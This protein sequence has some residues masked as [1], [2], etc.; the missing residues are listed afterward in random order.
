MAL[1][2]GRRG[3]RIRGWLGRHRALSWTA[4]VAIAVLVTAG[5]YTLAARPTVGET[6]QDAGISKIKHVVVIMQENRSFDSYFG[7]FPGADGIP[8]KGGVP[9]VCVPDPAKGTC[10]APYYDP[11]DKN[12]GGPHSAANATADIDGGKMDGFIA[13]A[14]NASSKCAPNEPACNGAAG[15]DVMGY[16]DARD[17]PNYWAYARDY[18][19]QDRMFEPNASWSLPAHLYMVSEWSAKCSTAGDPAS[20]VNAL[21]GPALPPDFGAGLRNTIIGQCRAGTATSA[22]QKALAAAGIS[23]DVAAQLHTFILQHCTPT[24]TYAECR[25]AVDKAPLPEGLR[26]KLLT[27]AKTIA[28]P[29]YAWTDLTYL[30]YKQNVSWGYYVFNG[31]EPD[32]QN[33][34]AMACPPVKQDAKTPGIWNP[35]PYFDTVKQDGQLGNIQSL[36]SFYSAAKDGTLPAV[37][38]IDPTDAVSEHP[39]ALV[40]AGQAYVSGLV[41]AVMSGP[42][43]GSTAIFLSWDDWGGFYDHVAPPTVDANGYGL[44]VPGIVISPYAKKGYIDHQTLSHDAYVKFIEDDFLHGA[45]I[46]PTTDGRPDP[47]PDVRENAPQL[48]D[49]VNDFDFTQPPS[50]PVILPNATTY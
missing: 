17:I 3:R 30:L 34:A 12:S 5:V 43:W 11:A 33:D 35:L 31:T 8:M 40:S 37:S 26:Q 50:R 48:G 24:E 7:T 29:D 20:C 19:L 13:Q 4:F 1:A 21:Q 41:N 23:P 6:V 9:A 22:C 36:T 42:D 2:R 45:R 14:E 47:R 32:C 38:W 18:V 49:L 28:P 16:H 39:P 44:R 10:V 25:A 15:T 27:V 46:D